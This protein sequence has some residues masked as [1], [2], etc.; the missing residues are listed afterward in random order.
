M[1][2]FTLGQRSKPTLGWSYGHLDKS[3]FLPALELAH[4][5]ASLDKVKLEPVG[6]RTGQAAGNP[7]RVDPV[8]SRALQIQGGVRGHPPTTSLSSPPA[9]VGEV[10]WLAGHQRRVRSGPYPQ[11]FYNFIGKVRA[12]ANKGHSQPEPVLC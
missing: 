11:E 1:G 6:G 3:G 7:D 5:Q 12:T 9:P 4:F 8:P 10:Y 2:S